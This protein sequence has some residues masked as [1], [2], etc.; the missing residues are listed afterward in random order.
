[1]ATI[2]K[3][4]PVI[5]GGYYAK[6]EGKVGGFPCGN[7][8]AWLSSPPATPGAADIA[9]AQ[10]VG[11]I[12]A[13]HWPAFAT[14]V[15]AT[16]YVANE[17]IVYP[18]GTPNAAATISPMIATGGKV[19][20]L[21]PMKLS[22]LISKKT[23][24]RGRGKTGHNYLGGMTTSMLDPDGVDINAS[25]WSELDTAYQ[26][27]IAACKTDLA[28]LVSGVVWQETVLSKSGTGNMW[29]VSA[30]VTQHKISTTRSRVS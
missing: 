12:M 28:A 6:V 10:G 3:P 16:E 14:A 22:R 4:L 27:F 2:P 19:G 1:M 24:T 25:E 26:A 13:T 29:V 5:P 8:F 11:N 18:L 7:T 15:F 21:A 23:A 17:V 30:N 9:I 20:N